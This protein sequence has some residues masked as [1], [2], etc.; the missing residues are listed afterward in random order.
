MIQQQS[1]LDLKTEWN[2]TQQ[3]LL[4][5]RDQLSMHISYGGRERGKGEAEREREKGGG[6]DGMEGG[7]GREEGREV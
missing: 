2:R 6:S 1:R 3:T 5:M 4:R 7:E